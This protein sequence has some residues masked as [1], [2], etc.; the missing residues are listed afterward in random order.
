[1]KSFD[2]IKLQVI[3]D[4]NTF[5]NDITLIYDDNGDSLAHLSVKEDKY[6]TVCLII[7]SYLYILG[8]NET[9]F[10]WLFSK[11]NNRE[12]IF[13]LCAQKGN[14]NIIHL[15]G[16]LGIAAANVDSSWH[17]GLQYLGKLI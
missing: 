3:S 15:K 13:D 8:I 4:L 11:N 5:T 2:E 14:I 16:N 7:D 1:M 6:E 9:F 12:N 17:I 10:N